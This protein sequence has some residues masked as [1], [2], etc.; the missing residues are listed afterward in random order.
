MLNIGWVS[1]D[2]IKVSENGTVLLVHARVLADVGTQNFVSL[3][4]PAPIRFMLNESPMSELADGEGNVIDNVKLAMPDAGANGKTVNWQSGKTG[5]V[6]VYPN[7]VSDIL[8]IEY[9]MET[10]GIFKAE[11]VTL[12]GVVIRSMAKEDS[13]AGEDQA[14]MNLMDIPNG[15]YLLRVICGE[16]QQN[17]KVVVFR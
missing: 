11:L 1:L 5:L 13:K 4:E 16:N 10:H 8:N 15:A 6:S 2:P 7:P 17:T 14:T 9:L 3:S 12:Q